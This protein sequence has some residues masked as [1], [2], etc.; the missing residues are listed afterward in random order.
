MTPPTLLMALVLT[1]VMVAMAIQL[2]A[3]TLTCRRKGHQWTR[4]PDDT[5]VCRRCFQVF[6]ERRLRR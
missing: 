4:E 2:T 3:R 6:A 1:L 5:L